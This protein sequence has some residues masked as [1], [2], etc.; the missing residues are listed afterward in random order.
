M[1]N[2]PVSRI[3]DS[4]TT[5]MPSAAPPV[6]TSIKLED[7]KKTGFT[8]APPI[9]KSTIT[10]TS[11]SSRNQLSSTTRAPLRASGGAGRCVA[12]SAVVSAM[13][14]PLLLIKALNSRDQLLAVPR[15]LIEGA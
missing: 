13:A 9:I 10:G 3:N 1:S 14:R 8:I 7:V 15:R 6:A 11:G 12:D 4:A 2:L 5:T